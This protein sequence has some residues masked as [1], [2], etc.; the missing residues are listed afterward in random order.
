MRL[1]LPQLHNMDRAFLHAFL[2]STGTAVI[3]LTTASTSGDLKY[4]HVES[5]I[6]KSEARIL[7][8]SD[9]GCQ[10]SSLRAACRPSF[11]HRLSPLTFIGRPQNLI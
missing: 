7:S 10:C 6:C 9:G 5:G 1:P 4:K 11:P 8:A 3:F 2:S